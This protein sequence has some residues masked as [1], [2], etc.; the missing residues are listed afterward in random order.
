MH[1]T[2]KI[3]AYIIKKLVCETFD[4]KVVYMILIIFIYMYEV[5]FYKFEFLLCG[6][7]FFQISVWKQTFLYYFPLFSI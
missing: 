4:K 6:F 1:G 2:I 7:F 5:E 3:G